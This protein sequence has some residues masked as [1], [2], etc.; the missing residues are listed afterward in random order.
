[1]KMHF[2]L[3]II[4]ASMLSFSNYALAANFGAISCK[5]S[6]DLNCYVVKKGD[7]WEK[8]FKDPESIHFVK[9][10][11]RT[12]NKLSRGMTI[13]VPKTMNT[14]NIMT[15]SPFPTQISPPGE[16]VIKVSL[17]TLAWGAYD[18]QGTLKNWGP[19]SGGKGFCPDIHSRCNT[20]TGNYK[21]YRKQGAN[22]ISTKFPVGRG[23]APMPYCMFFKGGFALHGS[24]D[25][26]GHNASHGC[27]RLVVSDAQW[28]NQEFVKDDE[29]AVKV[30][31]D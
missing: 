29:V 27:V 15:I 3:A 7:T 5:T 2:S 4:T 9:L 13:A 6:P 8:L 19:V 24:Y 10:L 11:N 28:I 17:K 31:R 18:S 30:S 25:V 1:M 16:K 22:C 26:P 21:I 14:T 12:G 20:P 23:G